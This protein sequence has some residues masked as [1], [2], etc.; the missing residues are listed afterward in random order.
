[1]QP[2]ATFY[3]PILIVC[4]ASRCLFYAQCS[5]RGYISDIN[6]PQKNIGR[7]TCQIGMIVFHGICICGFI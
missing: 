7:A 4:L 1:M 6:F 5:F 3:E 2:Q